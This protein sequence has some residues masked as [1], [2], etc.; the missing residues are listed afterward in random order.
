MFLKKKGEVNYLLVSIV[1]AL[2]FLLSYVIL[3]TD[4]VSN[5]FGGVEVVENEAILK[6]KCM[7]NDATLDTTGNGFRDDTIT[8][9]GKEYNCAKLNE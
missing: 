6:A 3:T 5:V 8:E 7:T 2:V 4:I 1:I 9:N